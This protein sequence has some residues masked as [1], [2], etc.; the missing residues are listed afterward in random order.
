MRRNE[1]TSRMI[2][3]TIVVAALTAAFAFHRA[4]DVP[5]VRDGRGVLGKLFNLAG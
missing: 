2:V 1:H 4:F 5:A 3:A